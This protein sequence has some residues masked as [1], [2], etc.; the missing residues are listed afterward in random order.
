MKAL[1]PVG[2]DGGVCPE[3]GGA[4]IWLNSSPSS[5]FVAS[6]CLHPVFYRLSVGLD[7]VSRPPLFARTGRSVCPLAWMSVP[8]GGGCGESAGGNNPRMQT[9][10]RRAIVLAA[11]Y[12]SRLWPL[13]A[14]LPKPLAPVAGRPAIGRVLEWLRAAG[15][16]DVVVNL[17]HGADEIWNWLRSA[18]VPDLRLNASFEPCLL[19]TGG[20]L[21]R[22]L[23]FFSNSEPFW[24]VNADIAFRV[25]S[26][27]PST[28]R[29][30]SPPPGSSAIS[31]REPLPCAADSSPKFAAQKPCARGT[32]TFCGL[33]LVQSALLRYA[34]SPERFHTLV[35]LYRAACAD[36]WIV[37]AVHLP[38]ACWADLGTA[39]HLMEANMQWPTIHRVSLQTSPLPQDP[40]QPLSSLRRRGARVRGAVWVHRTADVRPPCSI[41]DSILLAGATVAPKAS[42]HGAD[43]GR[44]A[45]AR[46]NVCG[47]VVRAELVVPEPALEH[48]HHGLGDRIAARAPPPRGSD[49]TFLR[50]RG[51]RGSVIFICCGGGRPENARYAAHAGFLASLGM[52]VPRVLWSDSDLRMLAVTDAGDT[53]LA[54]VMR[55]GSGVA[56][57]AYHR[58]AE[59]IARWHVEGGRAAR[60][61]GIG[62]EEPFGP[63]LW[64]REH[65]LFIEHFAICKCTAPRALCDRLADELCRVSAPLSEAP[66]SSSIGIFS[67]ATCCGSGAGRCSSTFRAC[68]SGRRCTIWPRCCATL[69]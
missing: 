36:G 12:G 38:D 21:A 54:D 59:V 24:I 66:R 10:P 61:Q 8:W 19:G 28:I 1:R 27:K 63:D 29:E 44:G 68:G 67:P 22:A 49:R 31:A 40:W 48:L 4:V 20:A 11:G 5:P 57:H 46:G 6:S 26:F 43:V 23:W 34:L 37:R 33:Q 45:V 64:A 65:Q 14:D 32:A 3:R 62:L 51:S 53:T 16:T 41:R 39:E 52:P 13:T 18:P 55:R 15:V 2:R 25:L 60:H 50:L 42:L 9:P 58:V 17:H 7:P 47:V 56:R 69:M 35:D 30:R